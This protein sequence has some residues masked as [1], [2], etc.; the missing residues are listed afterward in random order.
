MEAMAALLWAAVRHNR[1]FGGGPLKKQ[2]LFASRINARFY[3]KA[4]ERKA[5]KNAPIADTATN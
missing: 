1:T 2:L 3:K 5:I 4:L